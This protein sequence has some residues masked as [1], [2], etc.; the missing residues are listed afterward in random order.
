LA[1]AGRLAFFPFARALGAAG[2]FFQNGAG[3]GL[4]PFVIGRS[5]LKHRCIL[6][7]T[8]T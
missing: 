4:P 6:Y 8:E 7:V 3:C 2:F 1:L 5:S